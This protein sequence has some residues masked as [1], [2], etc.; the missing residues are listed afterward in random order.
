MSE[1][2]D[3]RRDVIELR[4]WKEAVLGKCKA[5]SGWD[6]LKWGGDKEGWGFVHYFIGHLNTR[7]LEAEAA[8]ATPT[9][10]QAP[11][12]PAPRGGVEYDWEHWSLVYLKRLRKLTKLIC[13]EGYSVWSDSDGMAYKL[14]RTTPVPSAS[15]GTEA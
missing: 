9:A 4:D 3:L 6:D 5:S 13:H 7:A 12:I 15:R 14:E 1:I 11:T 10:A 8:L 2:E